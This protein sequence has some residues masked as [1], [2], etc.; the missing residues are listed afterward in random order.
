MSRYEDH[1][2]GSAAPDGTRWRR[3]PLARIYIR[4][5]IDPFCHQIRRDVGKM[6]A[7][8]RQGRISG[9]IVQMRERANFDN[10]SDLFYYTFHQ[11]IVGYRASAKLSATGMPPFSIN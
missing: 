10:I 6:I 7:G 4:D 3:G 1:L 11:I 9:K 5:A 8:Q 2:S